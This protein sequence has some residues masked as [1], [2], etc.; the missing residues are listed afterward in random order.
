MNKAAIGRLRA[1]LAARD[2]DLLLV[3]SPENMVYLCGF[4]GSFGYL[5]ITAGRLVYATDFRYEERVRALDTGFEVVRLDKDYTLWDAV[6]ATGAARVAFEED[7]LSVAEMDGLRGSLPGVEPVYGA[8]LLKALRA[9][10]APA[11]LAQIEAACA[12]TDKVFDYFLNYV[13]PGLAECEVAEE[14]G[15]VMVKFGAAKPLFV[16][17]ASGLKTA[18]PHGTHDEKPIEAGDFVT[19]DMGAQVGH[20]GA[21]M[22]RT[23]VMGRATGEQKKIY[24]IVRDAQQLALEGIRPGI[25]GNMADAIARDHIA[26]KGY[27][28]QFG[29]GLGHG[30]GIGLGDLPRLNDGPAGENILEE[31]MVFS[32]EPGIYIPGFGGVRIEDTVLLTA[33]G[34]RPLCHSTKALLEV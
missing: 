16:S 31:N 6:R 11:E 22:T 18:M 34:C 21:D 13:R 8:A 28:A 30:V 24:G 2:I 1:A 15:R 5:L 26:Q 29:H 27:G 14:L 7:R 33:R 32:I 25:S 10:K 19:L 4:S 20:Y 23:V 9:V 3:S 17:V 12:I